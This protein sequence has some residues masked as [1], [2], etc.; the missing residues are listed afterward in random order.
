L[1]QWDKRAALF[2]T[3]ITAY[4]DFSRGTNNKKDQRQIVKF[5]D[6]YLVTAQK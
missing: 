1:Y 3:K 2:K 6:G 5:F 4:P